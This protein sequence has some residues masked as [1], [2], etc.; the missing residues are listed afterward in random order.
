MHPRFGFNCRRPIPRPPSRRSRLHNFLN[1]QNV[2]RTPRR[3]HH[4]QPNHTSPGKSSQKNPVRNFPA[5][6]FKHASWQIASLGVAALEMKVF[7]QDLAKQI[8]KNAQTAGQYL[9][10][11]GV[12]V[13]A[14]N[15]GFTQSHQIAVDIRSFGGGNKIAQDLRTPT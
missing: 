1:S 7:G 3:S 5:Q 12:K 11:N 9:C 6:R 4:G 14:E 13:L 8:V 2:P 15:K 10:E